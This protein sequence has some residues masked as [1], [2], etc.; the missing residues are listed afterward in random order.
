M[1]TI[2][3]TRLAAAILAIAASAAA[4]G[5]GEREAETFSIVVPAGTQDR[6][7]AGEVVE[8]MPER[9]ELRVGDRVVIRNDDEV[10]QAVGPYVVDAGDEITFTYGA[11]GVY[12]GFC[13]LSAS[14]TYEIV[15]ER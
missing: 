8:V 11:P 7:L 2:A 4:C 12:E 10:I 1:P 3:R 14:Q 5:G 9:I 6:L 15:V 13:A